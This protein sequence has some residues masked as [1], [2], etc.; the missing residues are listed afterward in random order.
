MSLTRDIKDYALDIGYAKVGVT[1]ADGFTDHIE[2]VRSRGPIYD[3]YA[4]DPRRFLDG[5]EPKKA[6]PTA[7]SVISLAWDYAQK[8]FPESLIGKV[9]RIYQAR[10]YNAPPD[11]I[12][13]AR[14]QLM[15]NFL[16]KRGCGVGRGI[17]IPERRAAARA[18]VTRF[19]RNNFAR[20]EKIGSFVLLGSFVV[21]RELEYDGPTYEIKC[22]EGCRA[23]MD[24]CPTGAIYEPLKLN[25]R[26][27][28]SFNAWWTQDGRPCGV[29]SYI[30]SD[31]RE[32]MGTRVHGCDACQ[33]AC[34][35]NAAKLKAKFPEDPFL[36]ELA[37]DF[38]LEKMLE[39]PG[40]FYEKRVR[41]IM[42]NYMN[43]KK[44]FRRNAAIALG[45]TGDPAHIP[46]LG[47]AMEDPEELARGYAAW[48]LGRIGG[49]KARALLE[50]R[51][52]REP[53]DF[54][55]SEIEAALER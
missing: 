42:F 52:N 51:L 9:G 33:E 40:D 44:Y 4:E 29:T 34:P 39:M 48:A 20:V 32:K 3:F 23:C 7:K 30:P 1:T 37:R 47:R 24:A 54:V 16:E 10:C 28:V 55:R 5:A 27:C 25:P 21:D 53:S 18:G 12:N 11:R 31:I 15:L 46:L 50:S 6:M 38:S 2:E 19:G 43:D 17:F 13:G 45:N 49:A 35:N 36:V 22:P 41:P 14:Y 26:R 8:A